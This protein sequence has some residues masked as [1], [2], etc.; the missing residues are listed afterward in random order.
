MPKSVKYL[1]SR[2][3]SL[4]ASFVAIVLRKSQN[5]Q[6]T[7]SLKRLI[8]VHLCLLTSVT[9]NMN[10]AMMRFSLQGRL[11]S[12]LFLPLFYPLCL[13]SQPQPPLA[14]RRDHTLEKHG[15]TRI[16]PYY[17]LNQREDPKVIAY[18]N[19]ENAYTEAQSAAW[20]PLA[21][22]VFEEIRSR[23]KED[24]QSVPYQ[25][26]NYWYYTRYEQGEQYPIYARRKG[27]MQAPE[28][29]LIHGPELAK[30]QAFFAVGGLKV[31]ENDQY[32]AYA[33][34]FVG[35]RQYTLFIKDLTTGQLLK[36]NF[37]NVTP[38]FVWGNNNRTLF[39]TKQDPE[40]LRW[41]QVYRHSLGTDAKM[42]DLVYEEKDEEF[43]CHVEKTKSKRFILI[44]SHQSTTSEYLY[45]DAY[46][47]NGV[48]QVFQPRERGIEY[49]VDHAD[50]NFYIRTNWK[51]QNFRLMRTH[52][53]KFGREH[54][55]EI[56]AHRPD[57]YVEAFELFDKYLVISE[58]KNG[59]LHLRI[60]PG[61]GGKE[62][63]IDFGEP[64][65]TASIDVNLMLET[66]VLRFRYESMTTPASTYAYNMATRE[67]TLLKQQ[68]VLGPFDAAN[69][70]TERLY[71]PAQDGT[72]IPISLVYRKDLRKETGNPTLLYGYGSYGYSIDPFFSMANLSLLDRGFVYA[73][74]HIRGGEEMG[75]AW[76]ENGKLLKKKN[77]FTDFV[78]CGQ[79]LIAQKYADPS[80]LFA[81]GGSAGGLLMGAVINLKPELWKGV[82]AAVPFVDVVTT[83]LDDSIPLTTGEYEEWGHPNDKVYY[84]YMLSYSPYDQVE[85]KAYPPL[86]VTAGLHDSQVQYWEP[87]KWVAKLR[88]LKTDQN[89]LLLKTNM[90][91]GHG[92]ASGRFERFKE[93]AFEYA[94]FLHLAGI[95][96]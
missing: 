42:D 22:K 12:C 13:M 17:W 27:S 86:L 18:L 39:Y 61:A 70:R 91:A 15:H 96:E 74:A 38:N 9:P 84:D 3:F 21:D 81:E 63:Y 14:E 77:T 64:A 82:I 23:I 36:E 65:Y 87:A 94:F 78:D 28:E 11:L 47:T 54:W 90:D 26:G 76:Y 62:H 72:P 19:A 31:S 41:H 34:D 25:D 57:V 93:V 43:S 44:G 49:S 33:I 8:L 45:L 1:G 95:Q 73:I 69:Y 88:T 32:L 68:P 60:R 66:N 50:D 80:L 51:A 6:S 75:R 7:T 40:T 59:L 83:M 35:R 24:D 4:S 55:K 30:G 71:A 89:L 92:G 79:Y 48:F 16:D 29:L 2:F 52:E 56:L 53:K 37:P 67:K 58:R 85:A 5:P 20:K 10:P 46:F